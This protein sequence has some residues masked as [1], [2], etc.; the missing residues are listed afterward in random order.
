MSARKASA[1]HDMTVPA[2]P[3]VVKGLL[4]DMDGTLTDSDTLHFEAY[5]ETLMKVGS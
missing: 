2:P 1:E 3:L 5:R 4:L